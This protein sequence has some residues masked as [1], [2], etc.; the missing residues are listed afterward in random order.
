M[1]SSDLQKTSGTEGVSGMSLCHGDLQFPLHLW[2]HVLRKCCSVGCH[3]VLRIGAIRRAPGSLGD[4][5]VRARVQRALLCGGSPARRPGTK[6][7]L[8]QMKSIE[9]RCRKKF[10][11]KTKKP[12]IPW[13]L[14]DVRQHDARCARD[15]LCGT[16]LR[17]APGLEVSH[18]VCKRLAWARKLRPEVED[19]ILR[20]WQQKIWDKIVR[21]PPQKRHILWI[22]SEA[23][24]RAR[25]VRRRLDS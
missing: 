11:C 13:D 18:A 12:F 16:R 25:R 19:Y 20:P 9:G 4:S 1:A 21:T 23:S 8:Q 22:G 7:E 10:D 3:V 5:I 15:R 2:T 24:L 17:K 6:I 14:P